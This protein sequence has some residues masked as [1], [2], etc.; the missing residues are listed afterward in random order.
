MST[1]GTMPEEVKL[2]R[3]SGELGPLPGFLRPLVDWVAR[4]DTTVHMKLLAGFL[5]IALLLLAMGVLSV[6][7]LSRV[8]GQVDALTAF[9]RQTDLARQMIYTVTAQMHYRAMALVTNDASWND[10]ITLAKEDFGKDLAE[11]RA[12]PEPDRK[13]FFD[14]LDAV[15][16]RFAASSASVTDLYNAG[17]VDDALEM[18]IAQEHPI[19]HQLEGALNTLIADSEDRVI[20]ET[21]AFKSDRGFLT[22][23]VGLFSGVSLLAALLLGAVLSWALIRPVRR[24]DQALALIADGDFQARVE[25]PN[26]DEFG[27]LTKNVNRTAE[28]LAVLYTDLESLNAH[29]QE[30][31]NTKAAEL[32]RASRLK[33]YLSPGLAESILS[34]ERDVQLDSSRKF[35]TVFF[36][37]VRGFTSAVERMEPEELVDQ[38][39][40]YLSEM[41]EIVF[42]HGGT[43]DKYVGDSL[44]VFFGDPVPQDDHAQRAVRMAFEMRDWSTRME[45][46]LLHTYHEAFRFGMGIATG[47][48]TVGDI[49]SSA[50]SDYTVLGKEVNLASRLADRAEAGQILVAERTMRA[51]E[52]FVD[53]AVIDEVGLKG[54][55]RPVTIYELRS[56][57]AP[58]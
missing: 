7:M 19:S 35:L 22:L 8:N 41:T 11:I 31:V 32:G 28:Q 46:R 4:V 29:L 54:I 37:D 30:M 15:N 33:R 52:A 38:L 17:R 39:N 49:G 56:L 2:Q 24:V 6:I 51:V 48:V 25:V 14:D 27:R 47:W 21:A 18:H 3:S 43:L 34:G 45:E 23:A 58:G 57:V 16:A 20:D 53:G 26:R 55:S 50:R 42:R 40:E 12:F 13:S 36:S 44:M 10:K 1:K 9:N 5:A